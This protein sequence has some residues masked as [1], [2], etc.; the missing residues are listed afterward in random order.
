[1]SAAEWGRW[2]RDEVDASVALPASSRR[3]ARL[4]SQLSSGWPANAGALVVNSSQ[5]GGAKDTWVL[6]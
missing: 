1:M 2:T 6:P 4:M 5:D 3:T